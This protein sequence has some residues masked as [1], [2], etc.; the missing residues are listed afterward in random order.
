[1]SHTETRSTI[2]TQL[3]IDG[4]ERPKVA[5]VFIKDTPID[6]AVDNIKIAYATGMAPGITRDIVFGMLEELKK[7]HGHV[8]MFYLRS[9]SIGGVTLNYQQGVTKVAVE[10]PV[11]QEGK[12]LT[13]YLVEPKKEEELDIGALGSIDFDAVGERVDQMQAGGGE[14]LEPSD[15]CEGGACKI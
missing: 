6:E 5:A 15:D 13:A 4:E 7:E 8:N 14:V 3:I 12:D 11:Q 1:M 10:E 9:M 2:E